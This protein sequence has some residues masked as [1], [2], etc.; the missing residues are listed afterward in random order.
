M[1]TALVVKKTTK[2]LA[3]ILGAVFVLA[4]IAGITAKSETARTAADAI[5][6]ACP[7]MVIAGQAIDFFISDNFGDVFSDEVDDSYVRLL[8]IGA[9]GDTLSDCLYEV[10]RYRLNTCY[11]SGI[12]GEYMAKEWRLISRN[13]RQRVKEAVMVF[14]ETMGRGICG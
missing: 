12:H 8:P 1:K 2:A 13:G 6:I 9:V 3:S 11:E 14:G 5:M 10:N 7:L 4:I